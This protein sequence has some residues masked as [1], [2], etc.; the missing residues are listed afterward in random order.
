[1]GDAPDL[2]I[3][4][5]SHD[6]IY[7]IECTVGPVS[8]K[9]KLQKLSMRAQRIKQALIS[10]HLNVTI[11]PLI[12]TWAK[13]SDVPITDFEIAEGE[14]IGVLFTEHLQGIRDAACLYLTEDDWFEYFKKLIP[15]TLIP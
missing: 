7:P 6:F 4:S 14:G 2:I 5:P 11:L 15:K 1:M 10:K 13:S 12:I 8:N 9:E 3:F